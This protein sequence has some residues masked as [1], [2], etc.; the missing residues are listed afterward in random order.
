MRPGISKSRLRFNFRDKE[1][2]L[3]SEE[4]MVSSLLGDSARSLVVG[5]CPKDTSATCMVWWRCILKVPIEV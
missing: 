2:S 1:I 5:W 3:A 4:Q